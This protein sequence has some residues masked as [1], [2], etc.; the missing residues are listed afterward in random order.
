V[1]MTSRF[2]VIA[3][4]LVG[5][6]LTS[7]AQTGHPKDIPVAHGTVNVLIGNKNGLVAVTDSRLSSNNVP[8]GF[9]QKLFQIDDH[10]IL[11]IAGWYS[12]S[13]PGTT[14]ATYPFRT[15]ISQI[16]HSLVAGHVLDSASMQDKLNTL[17]RVA[18][19]SF[20]ILGRTA[21]AA[22]APPMR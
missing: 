9:G 14:M 20:S 17:S 15:A 2:P 21:Q 7:S 12:V 18:A 3:L 13:G 22:G 5:V 19:A 16:V 8:V 10:T 1:L 4:V 6:V 11:T